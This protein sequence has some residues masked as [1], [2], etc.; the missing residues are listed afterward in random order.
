[1]AAA[2]SE[3]VCLFA[4]EGWGKGWGGVVGGGGG[5]WLG[6]ADRLA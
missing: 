6:A 4:Y 3:V 5:G 2:G 1:M